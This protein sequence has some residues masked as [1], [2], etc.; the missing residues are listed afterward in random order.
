MSLA[1]FPRQL[2]PLRSSP[3][4]CHPRQKK[5]LNIQLERTMESKKKLSPYQIA[6]RP[7]E[8]LLET[9]LKGFFFLEV[10][11]KIKAGSWGG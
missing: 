8:R 9:T 1:T 10:R 4:E 6:Q 5:T 11:K 7:R 3:S 2:R